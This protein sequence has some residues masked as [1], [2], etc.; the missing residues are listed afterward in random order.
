MLGSLF[1]RNFLHLNFILLV[2]WRV[3]SERRLILLWSVATGFSR[4]QYLLV[5]FFFE[6]G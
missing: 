4:F 5:F 6:E 2:G 3:S 1:L